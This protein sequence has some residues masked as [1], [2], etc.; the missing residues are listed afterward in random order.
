MNHWTQHDSSWINHFTINSQEK[1]W[2]QL[3]R[4][5]VGTEWIEPWRCRGDQY[6]SL[7]VAVNNAWSWIECY[8]FFSN[9]RYRAVLQTFSC[10]AMMATQRF[11]WLANADLCNSQREWLRVG[12]RYWL[13]LVGRFETWGKFPGTLLLLL[14]VGAQ[15]CIDSDMIYW[16]QHWQHNT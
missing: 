6:R 8:W 12:G 1:E 3:V 4:F 11:S 7:V 14:L 10:Q 9:K 15:P 5:T 16:Q 13:M 2:S